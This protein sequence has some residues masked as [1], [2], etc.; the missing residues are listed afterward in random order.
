MFF[1]L[2]LANDLWM[3]IG[4]CLYLWV[5][6]GYCLYLYWELRMACYQPILCVHTIGYG[7]G[8]ICIQENI[9]EPSRIF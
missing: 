3:C 5:W 8:I 7:L 6:I 1:P 2:R 4:Y 9:L